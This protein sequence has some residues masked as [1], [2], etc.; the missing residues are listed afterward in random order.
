MTHALSNLSRYAAA[1]VLVAA[2]L[3]VST[4]RATAGCG[5]PMLTL[6]HS[7]IND[8]DADQPS[9]PCHGP[10]CSASP[11]PTDLPLSDHSR[12][13][14]PVQEWAAVVAPVQLKL[15]REIHS[16]IPAS[17]GQPVATTSPPFH[18]PRSL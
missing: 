4:G 14:P 8:R 12:S 16:A 7:P 10:N 3:F 2:G 6:N 15:D 11:A 9:R 18:P 1:A 5:E 13:V 17:F